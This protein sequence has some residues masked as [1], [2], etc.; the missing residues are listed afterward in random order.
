MMLLVFLKTIT[1]GWQILYEVKEPCEVN[2]GAADTEFKSMTFDEL[3]ILDSPILTFNLS[4]ILLSTLIAFQ[5]IKAL[6]I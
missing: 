5:N 6:L 4:N 2:G 3:W 1:Y